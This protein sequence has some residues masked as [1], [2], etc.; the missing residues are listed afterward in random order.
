MP[1][2]PA[3]W[4]VIIANNHGDALVHDGRHRLGITI[5]SVFMG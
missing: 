3:P 1:S 2:T 4:R 5:P